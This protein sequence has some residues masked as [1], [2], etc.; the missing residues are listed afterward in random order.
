MDSSAGK[1]RCREQVGNF[2]AAGKFGVGNRSRVVSGVS[3]L[4]FS[5]EGDGIR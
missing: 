5:V 3:L 1:H 4:S 2:Y